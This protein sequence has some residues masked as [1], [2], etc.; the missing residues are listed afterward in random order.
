[1][2]AIVLGAFWQNWLR[3]ANKLPTGMAKLVT[4][5]VARLTMTDELKARMLPKVSEPT[6]QHC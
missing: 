4:A 6:I 5:R 3:C 2:P 1:M